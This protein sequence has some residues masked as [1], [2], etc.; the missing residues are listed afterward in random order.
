MIE[1]L[2]RNWTPAERLELLT[3]LLPVVQSD[4]YAGRYSE[5]GRPNITSLQLLASVPAEEVESYRQDI[6]AL[7]AQRPR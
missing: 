5:P 7:L 1:H 3:L 4:I 2:S 6:E